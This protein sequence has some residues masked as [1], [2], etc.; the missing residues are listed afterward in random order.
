MRYAAAGRRSVRRSPSRAGDRR[1]GAMPTLLDMA[2]P[3]RA[4]ECRAS[5]KRLSARRASPR[6]QPHVELDRIGTLAGAIS[7]INCWFSPKRTIAWARPAGDLVGLDA[8]SCRVAQLLLRR[9]VVAESELHAAELVMRGVAFFGSLCTAR[10]GARWRPSTGCR[11]AAPT[12]L[13][14]RD[15]ISARWASSASAPCG[16][17][18]PSSTT[19]TS[20][21]I[22]TSIARSGPRNC[23]QLLTYRHRMALSFQ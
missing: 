12:S 7:S 19:A 10:G 20:S 18:A 4:K 1:A 9:R 2:L 3:L 8:E 22:L 6:R 16:T 21:V 11:P 15:R 5:A 13:P 23:C 17:P 14:R